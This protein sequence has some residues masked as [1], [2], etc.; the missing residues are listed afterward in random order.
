MNKEL[1]YTG[2]Y[3]HN[4]FSLRDKKGGGENA[5]KRKTEREVD[6]IFANMC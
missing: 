4:F 2:D 6:E 5:R 1:A 3:T